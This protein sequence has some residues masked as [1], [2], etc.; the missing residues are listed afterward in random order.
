MLGHKTSLKK[1][2][3]TE[4]I[5]SI[6]SNRNGMRLE[7]SNEESWK[8]HKYVEIKQHTSEQPIG[9]RRNKKKSRDKQ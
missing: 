1:F 6:F 5:L 3:Q 7:I 4:I 8:L 9:Q 2:K